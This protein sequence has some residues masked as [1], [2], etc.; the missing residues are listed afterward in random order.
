MA[1][2]LGLHRDPA[3][4]MDAVPVLKFSR[5]EVEVRRRTW[6]A[7]YIVDKY[8]HHSRKLIVRYISAWQG[9]PT[10]I[11]NQEF[12][13][14]FP[15]DTVVWNIVSQLMVQVLPTPSPP[16]LPFTSSE[17]SF[18]CFNRSAM[19]STSSLIRRL[20]KQRSYKQNWYCHSI[21]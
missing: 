4:W 19:L 9:R 17:G 13:T 5:E 3:G 7:V 11:V 8:L 21:R 10:T 18:A 1:Q 16:G 20:T 2:D 6:W 15:E 14:R 12:D